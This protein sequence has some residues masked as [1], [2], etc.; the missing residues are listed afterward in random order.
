[1]RETIAKSTK[2]NLFKFSVSLYIWC[3]SRSNY[4]KLLG[5]FNRFSLISS[6]KIP[7]TA[8]QNLHWAFFKWLNLWEINLHFIISD[9]VYLVGRIHSIDGVGVHSVGGVGV[10]LVGGIEL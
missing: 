2:L 5:M 1:M 7:F 6:K 3:K 8:N 10:H 9:G 4:K